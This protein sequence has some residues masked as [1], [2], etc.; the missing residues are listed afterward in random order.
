MFMSPVVVVEEEEL[1]EV[2]LTASEEESVNGLA[3][4]YSSRSATDGSGSSHG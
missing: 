3:R 2:P 4:T 1:V